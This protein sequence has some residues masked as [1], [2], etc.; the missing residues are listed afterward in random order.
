LD[1]FFSVKI[2]FIRSIQNVKGK[3][4]IWKNEESWIKIVDNVDNLVYKSILS[5][6]R[7][8]WIKKDIHRF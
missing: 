8:L 2:K 5:E 4:W 6:K 1:V 7:Y 3:I